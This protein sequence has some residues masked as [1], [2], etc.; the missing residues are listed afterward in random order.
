M[1]QLYVIFALIFCFQIKAQVPEIQWEQSY[2]GIQVDGANSIIQTA[3]GGYAI[4][5]YSKSND[6]DLTANNGGYDYWVMKTDIYGA[7]EWQHNFGGTLDDVATTIIETSTGE[8]VV[9]GTAKSTDG[10]VTGY[11]GGQN[12]MW[13]VKLSATGALLWEN[14]YGGTS[15]DMGVQVIESTDGNY[16]L[17]GQVN[18]IRLIKID[19]TGNIIWEYQYAG[20]GYGKSVTQTSDG[21]YAISG[22]VSENFWI[23]KLDSNGVEEWSQ[24]YG[25]NNDN[26]DLPQKIIQDSDGDLVLVGYS[27][28][29]GTTG[30]NGGGIWV[31][32]VDATTGTLNWSNGFQ[33]SFGYVSTLEGSSFEWGS[34]SNEIIETY[35]GGYALCGYSLYAS[36]SN[37]N[38]ATEG[39]GEEDMWILKLNNLGEL[40]WQKSL[41]SANYDSA[42][43]IIE[44]NDLGLAVAG[45]YDYYYVPNEY[46][47]AYD[48]FA[49]LKIIKFKGEVDAAID[50]VV[51][52]DYCSSSF[53][54]TVTISNEDL[55]AITSVEISY[56]L[57]ANEAEALT[58]LWEGTLAQGETINIDLPEITST[59]GEHV[60]TTQITAVNGFEDKVAENN[61]ATQTISV[62]S[63]D[64]ESVLLSIQFDDWPEDTSW[65]LKDSAGNVL[66]SRNMGYYTTPQIGVLVTETLTLTQDDC[67][68]FTINDDFE[69]GLTDPEGYYRLET[70]EGVIFA[71]N[72]GVFATETTYFGIET[73][74]STVDVSSNVSLKLYPNPVKD[75]LNVS[76]TTIEKAFIYSISGQL[77]AT[78]KVKNNQ[79]NLTSMAVGL[80]FIKVENDNGQM[81]TFKIIKE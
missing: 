24:T 20:W 11:I 78:V 5:G 23:A 43:S 63:F 27:Y 41:G 66:Y 45:I 69:D 46:N 29:G 40:I 47:T 18:G 80:Y 37:N 35:D 44:T 28:G 51:D 57:D 13:V 6:G 48:F 67:Y 72:D 60:L 7:I 26:F 22:T 59:S 52:G 2:G 34:N 49:D 21:G 15:D 36:G 38:D 14:S 62:N 64:T 70:E 61:A 81:E 68:E 75:I 73:T 79:I 9:T 50:V 32:N 53:M 77:I 3:D 65:E 54:P 10:D 19:T 56:Y 1:K 8:F 71:E 17:S 31:I 58:Y 16:L 76:G 12:D 30:L 39:F 4:A 55:I 42:V 25:G 74:L 33:H